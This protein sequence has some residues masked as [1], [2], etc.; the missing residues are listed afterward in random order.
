M[1]KVV[2]LAQATET[3]VAAVV[4]C[5]PSLSL[6]TNEGTYWEACAAP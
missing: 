6:A 2:P 1:P 4:Q 3:L 5:I